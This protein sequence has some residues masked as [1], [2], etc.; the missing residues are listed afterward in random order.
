[1][2]HPKVLLIGGNPGRWTWKERLQDAPYDNGI[3]AWVHATQGTHVDHRSVTLDD[4]NRHDVV[5]CNTN[6]IFKPGPMT[7][8]VR[9]AEERRSNVRWVSLLEGDMRDYMRP[10]A[11][12]RRAFDASDLVNCINRH[13]TEALQHITSTPVAYVGIP[14]P[15]DGVRTC[16]T[17]IVERQRRVHIC[18][19]VLKRLN[20]HIV[21]RQLGLPID[22]YQSGIKRRPAEAYRNWKQYRTLLDK[23]AP[24][25]MAEA[26]YQ[27]PH[28]TIHREVP[29]PVYYKAAGRN[30]LWI[31]MDERFTWGRY[32]LDAAALGVPMVTT[33]STG[34]ADVLFPDTTVDTA[35][36]VA[37]AAR[38]ARRLLDDADFYRHV[39]HQAQER[40]RQYDAAGVVQSL[41]QHLGV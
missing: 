7:K 20:D 1:M 30:M 12:I 36:D 38:L 10:D 37:E 8:Y 39:S 3:E 5:I 26:L 4:V 19:F 18:A 16:A 40:V 24:F 33:R 15:V 22:G 11:L 14:Y 21:A 27:D 29:M 25:A 2:T 17:P 23:Q 41:Y 6:Y 32:V 34:H 31:N 13:A 35:F 9:L 28:L